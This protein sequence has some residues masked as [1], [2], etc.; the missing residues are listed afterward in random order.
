MWSVC[1]RLRLLSTDSV[2]WSLVMRVVRGGSRTH[3][4]R[5]V[6]V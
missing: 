2:I 6:F 3:V 1:N 5:S 4:L